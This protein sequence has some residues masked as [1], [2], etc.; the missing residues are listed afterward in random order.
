MNDKKNIVLVE[1]ST[2]RGRERWRKIVDTAG[3]LFEERGFNNVS[4]VEIVRESGGSLSTVYQWFGNKNQLFFHVIC[5]RVSE[6][7]ARFSSI[8]LP[9]PTAKDDFETLVD[10]VWGAAPFQ[11]ARQAWFET[12]VFHEFQEKLFGVIEQ[13][14]NVPLMATFKRIREARG[15][16]F[17]T[18]DEDLVF[19]FVRYFRGLFFEFALD[20]TTRKR[21]MKQSKKIIVDVLV[22]L[23]Q[24][25]QKGTRS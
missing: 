7:G 24:S 3:R 5:A 2:A 21:R 14:T 10:L 17:K 13:N 4:L 1:P 20:E 18:S 22:S 23:L 19:L 8:R 9:G 25:P 6:V 12:S 15:V 16:R 11:F